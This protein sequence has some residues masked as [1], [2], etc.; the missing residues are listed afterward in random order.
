MALLTVSEIS[1]QES[2]IFGL[3]NISFTQQQFQKLAIAG[4]TGAGKSTLL[5][6]IAGLVS[7]STGQVR[8]EGQLVEDPHEK[9]IPGHAGIAYLSQQFELAKFLRVEQ[10]L[11]YADK[12]PAGQADELY[13]LCQI[14][15]L[16]QR[17]TNQL[18]GGERQRIA[19]AR[20]LL[21][22]PR[23]LLLD[24][25]FSNL[26]SAHKRTLKAVIGNVSDQ[27]GI[28]CILISHDPLDTLSWAEEILVLQA[29][30]I[31]QR[32]TPEQ[33]YRQPVNEYV[34]A[35]FGDYNLLKG[36][37]A[38]ALATAVNLQAG[39]KKLLIRPESLQIGPAASA[40]LV[41][42]VKKATFFGSY[43]ELEILVG[44]SRI[45]VRTNERGIAEGAAVGLYVAADDIR[46]L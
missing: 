43:F 29:G 39:N 45:R 2:G 33:V 3:N 41:G 31:V 35:L 8:F 19:L 12:L 27:L 21:T 20:L 17:K 34:A 26:D 44:R 23:L 22:S 28:T 11:R 46:A 38:N 36:S 7:P 32:G 15:H 1:F 16:L 42:R 6:I 5:Q 10:V 24:E 30:E 37:A 14:D 9:L 13:E 4:E 40:G 25:P 18:S